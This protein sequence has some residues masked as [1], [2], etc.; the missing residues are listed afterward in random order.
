MVHRYSNNVQDLYS[1][2]RACASSQLR[3][4]AYYARFDQSFNSCYY[5]ATFA[6][7]ILVF[8]VPYIP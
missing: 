8:I 1:R 5:F 4:L 6:A 2:S 3:Q 7:V